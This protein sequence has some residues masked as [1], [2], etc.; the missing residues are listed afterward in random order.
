[1]REHAALGDLPDAMPQEVLVSVAG[2]EQFALQVR[3]H[4]ARDVRKDALAC[5]PPA[6]ELLI[7]TES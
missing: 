2:A 7:S 4:V 5:A 3:T 1:M 6:G